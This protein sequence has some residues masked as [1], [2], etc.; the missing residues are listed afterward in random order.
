MQ[1]VRDR[2]KLLWTLLCGFYA[3]LPSGRSSKKEALGTESFQ[4]AR[5]HP[6]VGLAWGG[7]AGEGQ[8]FLVPRVT[9]IMQSGDLL[10]HN[11]SPRK[12]RVCVL[13]GQLFF[14]GV[15]SEPTA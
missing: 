2:M 13:G 5:E 4:Q 15:R 6:G 11:G 3:D 8:A 9:F 7:D 1:P 10:N 12:A 14:L